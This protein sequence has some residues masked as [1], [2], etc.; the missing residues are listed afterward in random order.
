MKKSIEQVIEIEKKAQAIKVAALHEAELLPIQA[1]KEAQSLLETSRSEAEQEA[2]Q[3]IEGSHAEQECARIEKEAE[4]Q[5]GRIKVV[6]M[7]R[8][9]AAINYVHDRLA[10]RE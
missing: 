2:R 8:F 1:Q 6:A 3:L 5:A 7:N 10:G 9:K 4:E